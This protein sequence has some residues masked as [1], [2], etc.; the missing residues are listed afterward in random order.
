MGEDLIGRDDKNFPEKLRVVKP[1]VKQIWYRGKWENNIFKKCCAVVGSRKMSR[2]GK[3]V[4]AE[5]IPK[6]C[7]AGYSIVS[8]LMYGVDQEAHKLALE[9]GGCAIGILGWGIEAKSEEGADKLIEKIVEGGGLILSEYPDKTS[10][11]TWT[12]PQRNRIVVALSEKVIVVE[13]GEKS[14]SLHTV[15]LARKQGKELLA[16]PGSIFSPTSVGTNNLIASGVAKS[17]MLKNTHSEQV[18]RL[19]M[20]L[21]ESEEEVVGFLK[22]EGPMG[23]NEISRRTGSGA[24]EILSRLMKLEM[25]GILSEERGIWRML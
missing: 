2:Y 13:A 5:M 7:N 18:Q 24:G 9:C 19:G 20:K 12:F 1:V 14:G 25:S 3:Q 17:F 15:A 10:A 21:N 6:L 4:L 11:R 23:V 16:V 8:G 22:I